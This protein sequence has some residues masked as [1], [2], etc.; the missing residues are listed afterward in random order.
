MACY[1]PIFSLYI[2]VLILKSERLKFSHTNTFSQINKFFVLNL[3][4]WSR[5]WLLLGIKLSLVVSELWQNGA[6]MIDFPD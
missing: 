4:L 2:S 1:A 3:C 6:V 5:P